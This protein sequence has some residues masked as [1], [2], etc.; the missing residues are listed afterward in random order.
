MVWWMQ[1]AL[2]WQTTTLLGWMFRG[3]LAAR[4][5]VVE[6]TMEANTAMRRGVIWMGPLLLVY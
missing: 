2:G 4:E 6:V 5:S 1:P 3:R